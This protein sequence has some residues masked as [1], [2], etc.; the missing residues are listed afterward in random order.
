MLL[1]LLLLLLML[2]MLLMLLFLLLHVLADTFKGRTASDVVTL[3]DCTILIDF[4]VSMAMTEMPTKKFTFR[5]IHPVEDRRPLIRDPIQFTMSH[6]FDIFIRSST[7]SSCQICHD[8]VRR[9]VHRL[10]RVFDEPKGWI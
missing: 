3:R 8:I 2:L 7:S 1:L 4:P 5:F 10:A 9:H 6:S